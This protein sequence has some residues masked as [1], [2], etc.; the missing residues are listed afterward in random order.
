[1]T[2]NIAFLEQITYSKS[3]INLPLEITQHDDFGAQYHGNLVRNT[4]E[5]KLNLSTFL[6]LKIAFDTVY[7]DIL[8]L[9]FISIWYL[10][11]NTLLVQKV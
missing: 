8:L 10:W 4:D 7:Y 6:D 3:K 2:T 11:E 1:M 5:R 9:K